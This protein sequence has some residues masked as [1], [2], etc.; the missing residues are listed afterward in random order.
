MRPLRRGPRGAA[1][2]V[3]AVLVLVAGATSILGGDGAAL[4]ASSRAAAGTVLVTD[5][6]TN[7]VATINPTTGAVSSVYGAGLNGP[8]GIAVSPD[9]LTA[10]V[11]NSL[12]NTV[13]PIDLSSFP[14]RVESPIKVGGAPSAIALSPNGAVAYVSDFNSNTVTPIYLSSRSAQPAIHVG[15][16]PWSL[17]VST[18]G[19]KVI[20]S[21]SEATTVSVIDVDTRHVTTLKVGG[22]PEAIAVSPRTDVAYVLSGSDVVP[23][24]L[25][26]AAPSLGSPIVVVNKPVGISI[27]PS[28]TT[29]YTVNADNTVTRI[30][31]A[32]SPARVSSPVQVGSLSQADGVAISPDGKRAYIA[33]ATNTVTPISLATGSVLAQTPVSVGAASFGVAVVP[34]QA[35]LARFTEKIG[36][37]GRASV[38]NASASRSPNG[39]IASYHWNFGNGVSRVSTSA[40]V[41]YRYPEVGTYRVSLS[42]V[43]TDGT[44]TVRTFTGQS[45]SNNGSSTS[46]LAHV[47]VIE[48]PLEIYPGHG[49]PGTSVTIRD[50]TLT[51][52]CSQLNIYFDGLLVAQSAPRAKVLNDPSVVIPGDAAIGEHSVAVSCST[53]AKSLVNVAF[54]VVSLK[55]HLSEF[56]VAMPSPGTL[57]KHLATAGLFG[58]LF[59]LFGRIF[60]AGFP[61]EWMD[62]TY[63]SNFERSTRWFRRRFPWLFID[64]TKVRRL[65]RRLTVG[66]GLLVVFVAAASLIDS[67]LSPGFGLNRTS[68]WL[69]LGQC[70]GIGLITLISQG[71]IALLGLNEKKTVHLHVLVGGLVIAVV[72]VVASRSLGLAPGYCYGLVAIYVLRP[73]PSLRTEGRYHFVSSVVVLVV[74]T[75]AFFLTVPVFRAATAAHPSIA[76]LIADPA[77]NMVF[78]GGFSGVAFGMFPLPFLPGHGVARWNRWA[79]A[80]ISVVGLVGYVGVLLSPGSG[81][82]AEL[83]SVGMV[84]LLTAFCLFALASVGFWAYHLWSAKRHG[85]LEHDEEEQEDFEVFAA[86]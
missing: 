7:S 21:N 53:P 35:P 8:L 72:C 15:S 49:A 54:S 46:A 48:S 75:A 13:S 83:H 2:A 12:G 9:G 31:L 33:N 57:K 22:R 86:E 64:R 20:V 81:T 44:S 10:Y 26:S 73:T 56:S 43:S 60:A 3:G 27:N 63:A 52:T 11:T 18:D 6:D 70:A 41:K 24:A 1:A 51:T 67:F 65:S 74:A 4:A 47:A 38:F 76:A 66:T 71:P 23:I 42:V 69:Y 84:P 29:A 78:L 77:L 61:S 68:L 55:N 58:L 82:A 30:D 40:I 59:L 79:W 62:R 39:Q 34:D 32:V 16:G 28:G 19:S 5:L 45:V 50:A 17:A 14:F 36:A 80:A 37:A 25:S 85:E